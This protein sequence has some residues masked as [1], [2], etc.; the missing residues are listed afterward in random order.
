MASV[1]DWPPQLTGVLRAWAGCPGSNGSTMAANGWAAA[2]MVAVAVL[3]AD[4]GVVVNELVPLPGEDEEELL[5]QPVARPIRA[6]SATACTYRLRPPPIPE[7]LR[8]FSAPIPARAGDHGS[9]A[10]RLQ[11]RPAPNG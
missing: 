8:L 3:P 1:V 2:E 11:V 4:P 6:A 10:L 9:G 5:P 7:H